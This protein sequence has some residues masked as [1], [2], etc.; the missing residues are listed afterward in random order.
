MIS[1][2]LP[3]FLFSAVLLTSCT[4]GQAD[5][6]SIATIVAATLQV[7]Q[8][9]TGP[10]AGP[11]TEEVPP[12]TGTVEGAICFPSEGIPPMNVY[13]QEQAAQEPAIV[14]IAQNQSSYSQEVPAGTYTAFAWMPD[15]SLGGSYSQAVACGL[16]ADC[17]DHSLLQFQVSAGQT[18]TDIDVCDW[19]G[20]PD[21]VPLPPGVDAQFGSIGGKLSYPSSFI[22]PL[23]IVAFN[24]NSSSWQMI[25]TQQN[26]GTYQFD[27]LSVGTYYV[28]AYVTGDNFGGGYT[29]AVPCGLSVD[30]TDH[31]LLPVTVIANQVTSGID[32]QD[33]Y[34]PPDA[35]P[36][37][38]VP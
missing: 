18:T 5:A 29:A 26:Q 7:A 8:Q 20:E 38:P 19:Y 27:G 9:T 1:K 36:A 33:W 4:G 22:P 11:V 32:P 30:C 25:Q 3:I 23:T 28:V 21:D 16:S 37:N 15:F 17:S 34:A 12:S 24:T 31:S 13:L 35:F 14:P 6:D 10:T 2:I